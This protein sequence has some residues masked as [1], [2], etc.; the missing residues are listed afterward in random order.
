[1]QTKKVRK[2]LELFDPGNKRIWMYWHQGWDSAPELVKFCM[3]TWIYHN[4]DWSVELLSQYNL[5]DFITL[6]NYCADHDVALPALSDI[7]RI[8]LLEKYGGVWADATTWCS[9]PLSDWVNVAV[10]PSGFFA[11]DKPAPDRPIASWFL[12]APDCAARI[13]LIS[14]AG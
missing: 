10:T 8:Y 12:V 14:H 2:D 1:M 4:D 5:N 3:L 9:R 11:Y 7:I 13:S 6:P